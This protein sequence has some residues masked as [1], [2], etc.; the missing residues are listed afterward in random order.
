MLQTLGE[1]LPEAARRYGNKTALVIDGR[2]FTFAELEAKSNAF[3]NGLTAAGIRPGDTITL[4]GPNSWQ[5]M[6]AY[7]GV[8]KTGAAVNPVNVM[9]TPEELGF[10]IK[11]CGARAVV[12][13]ADKAAALMDMKGNAGLA[14]VVVWGDQPPAGATPFDR[15]L[16]QGKET[17]TPV[18]RAPKDTGAICYTSGTTGHPKG[19]V[20][21]QRSIVATAYGTALMH[22]R[23]SADTIVSPLPCVH[24]YGSCVFNAAML[25]G[26]TMV[27]LPRF[28]E[29]GVL[30]AIQKNRATMLDSVPTAY[31]YML[32]HPKFANYDLSSLTRCTVGGQ[33][34]PTA[35]SVEWT[36]RTKAPVLELWGMTELAGAATF[37]P[38]WGDNKPGTIGLPM[39]GMFCRIVAAEDPDKEMPQGERGELMI[40]GA[41][42]MDGYAG[43]DKATRETVRADGWMHT[44]DIATM[45]ADGYYTIVDRKKD[46]ILTAGYNVYPAEL[47]RV[48]CMHPSVALAA[49][50]GVADEAKGELAKAYVMLK[51]GAAASGKDLVEHCRQHLAAYKLPRA[52]QFVSSVPI[53]PSGKILR[54]LLKDVDD[55]TR[56]ASEQPQSRSA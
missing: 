32:S 36:E 15:W 45:D 10:I 47:E 41:L 52:V 1:I 8:A 53:T 35:K 28:T 2:S 16:A 44:G 34:L 3:A 38:Y 54:R 46:M 18:R 26:S 17:F 24:V 4:Y 37:N 25:A 50:C 55:G 51:P 42:V 23:S 39:P 29:E 12:A 30:D 27:I 56:A 6:V 21:S 22:S 5:W 48:L 13:S 11:D 14:E 7:Y 40:K 9:L 49:V 43:N 20:Q 33:T 19:A 31:Y